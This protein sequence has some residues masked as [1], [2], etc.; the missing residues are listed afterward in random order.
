MTDET[1][2]LDNLYFDWLIEHIEHDGH[3]PVSVHVLRLMH[4]TP[5]VAL[6]TNDENR[7]IEGVAL[8]DKFF[9]ENPSFQFRWSD[10]WAALECSIFEMLVALSFRA[11]YQTD[12]DPSWWFSIF[13]SNLGLGNSPSKADKVLQALNHRKYEYDGYGGLFPL[14]HPETDQRET[15]LWY[16]LAAYILENGLY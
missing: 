2:P 6:V 14:R 5:F 16:Q 7:S 15:E 4:K 11:A 3:V 13:V 9:E 8:R 1:L 10:D 12:D